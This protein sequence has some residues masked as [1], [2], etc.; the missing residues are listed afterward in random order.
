MTLTDTTARQRIRT[1]LVANRGEIA[2]RVIRSAREMGIET[3]A[4]YSD[5]DA[6]ALF[7]R[8]ADRAVH[9]PGVAPADT[10]LR[11][12]LILDAA[13]RTGADAI[14]PGYGFLSE[15][16]EFAA[17]VGAAG[18]TFVGPTPDAMS[19][20]GSKIRAKSLME[21]SGV[22]VL[23]GGTVT[24][25]F[26]DED[27][28]LLGKRIGYPVLV[29]ASAGGGGRG[30]RIVA[31]PSDLGEAV[32]SARREA[33]SAFGDDT[34]FLER[35]VTAPRHIEVQIFGDT[36]GRVI[37][38]FERDCSIQRRYQKI[39]EESPS[40]VVTPQLRARLGDAAI[41]AG[42]AI[43][44]VGAGTVEF[45]LDQSGDF[46]FL[47]VNT[48]LQVEHPVTESVTGLD[49]V[50]LQLLVAQGEELPE[51]ART[52]SMTGHAIEARLYAEDPAAGFLPTSGVLREFSLGAGVRADTGFAA[53]DAVSIHYDPMLAKL[54]A[55]APTRAEAAL[56]LA[57]A[58]HTS[59]IHGVGTNREVLVGI[60]RESE[61]LAGITDTAYLERHSVGELAVVP[62]GAERDLAAAGAVLALRAHRRSEA[63]VQRAVTP[64]FR[65]LPSQPALV[66]FGDG[67]A[68]RDVRYRVTEKIAEISVDELSLGRISFSVEG[69]GPD[70]YAVNLVVNGVRESLQVAIHGTRI[71][72]DGRFGGVEL[73]ELG[74]LP[75]PGTQ[76]AAGSLAAPMP[77]SVVRLEV[78]AGE[79]V[80]AGQIVLVLEAMKME[81]VVRAPVDGTVSGILV[82]QGQ[83]VD[84]GQI[85]AVVDDAGEDGDE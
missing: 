52:A 37:S 28:A 5:A 29:K 25:N 43:G 45:I 59:R 36:T 7:V 35:Y 4:V 61:F 20:M 78:S 63:K 38:L 10:Y 66:R 65:N 32:A 48:R 12:D 34:V 53:G 76:A 75:E 85:L 74:L 55:H 9:L 77:G 46:F 47:E 58:L 68:E 39:I 13:R 22:P 57:R 3:V 24:N 70:V 84:L 81:H 41:A 2:V 19:A 50:R 51:E 83:Q 8:E 82:E 60:L 56:A 69:I 67:R 11:G 33:G 18:I 1:L 40:P 64:G 42:E 14:H 21:E 54:I 62:S 26:N 16:A 44:Y 79:R 49:L 73:I 31:D 6:D 71:D 72:I 30:M 17:S 80:A 27:L 23:P 15:N